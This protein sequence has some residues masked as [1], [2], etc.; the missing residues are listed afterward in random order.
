MRHLDVTVLEAQAWDEALKPEFIYDPEDESKEIAR[1]FWRSTDGW[2]GHYDTEPLDGA[3]WRHVGDGANCGDWG[4]TPPG[5]S[6]AE[7]EE[8]VAKL[9]AEHGTILVI[10]LPTSNV[11]STAFDVY[12]KERA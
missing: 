10:G 6:N 12:A 9:E 4:D 8:Y 11:F 1:V 5:T 7:V 2:R 3:G